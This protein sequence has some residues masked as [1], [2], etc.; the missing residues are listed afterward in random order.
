MQA[1][2]KVLASARVAPV[3]PPKSIT[4]YVLLAPETDAQVDAFYEVAAY[5]VHKG[6]IGVKF[7]VSVFL[8]F[9]WFTMHVSS[10]VFL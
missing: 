3:P 4:T 1:V 2:A 10:T 9:F 7:V 6:L 5:S 8:L